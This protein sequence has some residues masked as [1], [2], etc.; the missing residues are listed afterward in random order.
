AGALHV[1]GWACFSLSM[2]WLFTP[3]ASLFGALSD[4]FVSMEYLGSGGA[5][6]IAWSLLLFNTGRGLK[7]GALSS[8]AGLMMLAFVRGALLSLGEPEPVFGQI[9]FVE[10]IAFAGAASVAYL[11]GVGD[12]AL[13]SR[14]VDGA[15][16]L[17]GAPH[18]VFW[19]VTL[20]LSPVNMGGLFFLDHPIGQAA[21]L[22]I[23]LVVLW[24]M[25]MLMMERGVS[26]ATSMPHVPPF[27]LA[28]AFIL[29]S[30]LGLAGEPVKE[31]TP[32]Y[33][34]A[35]TYVAVNAVSIGFDIIDS[36]RWIAGERAII[37]PR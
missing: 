7:A 13:V 15:K 21:T 36:V 33:V 20:I 17:W 24:N 30:L 28:T 34:F 1:F 2:A 23:V 4:G 25:P 32:L 5:A 16:S 31:G 37:S 27:V 8:A 35:W 12:A 3:E 29:A 26:K 11:I 18:W 22:S 10:M 14:F 9:I 6:L 19:W